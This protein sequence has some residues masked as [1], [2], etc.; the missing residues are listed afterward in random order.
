MKHQYFGD[1][2]DY[3]KYCIL[4]NLGKVGKL[5]ILVAWMLTPDDKRTDGNNNR[6][7]KNAPV[8]RK[9][10]PF[11]FD[12]LHHNVVQKNTKHLSAIEK[13][14]LLSGVRFYNKILKDD[15]EARNKYFKGLLSIARP[16][17][18]VFLDPDNGI[19]ISS[20]KKGGKNSSKYI[21]LDEI[22]RFWNSGYSLLIYQHFPRV[23]RISYIKTQLNRLSKIAPKATLLAVKTAYMAYF[24]VTTE[25]SS[26]AIRDSLNMTARQWESHIDVYEMDIETNT[27]KPISP[28]TQNRLI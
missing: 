22:G 16:Y 10:D 25:K 3:K 27:L 13:S 2:S 12:F 21:F 23:E 17:D 14:G 26:K 4:K 9:Y 18:L 15:I 6:Y 20:V 1:I 7:L 11:I 28:Y 24:V 5:S 19:E 8:W